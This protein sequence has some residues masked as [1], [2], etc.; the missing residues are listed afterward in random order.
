M[1]NSNLWISSCW[2]PD[3]VGRGDG[4]DDYY[5]AQ[6]AYVVTGF[7]FEILNVNIAGLHLFGQASDVLE[8]AQLFRFISIADRRNVFALCMELI[9]G[10]AAESGP[11][12]LTICPPRRNPVQC[13][14]IV[15]LL[16]DSQTGARGFLWRMQ[17]STARRREQE[18]LRQMEQMQAMSRLAH[19]VSHEFRNLLTG[20][21]IHADVVEVTQ[22]PKG[23]QESL[24]E[25]RN[26]CERAAGL[27]SQLRAFKNEVN[28]G[29]SVHNIE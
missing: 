27:L 15:N 14:A 1:P 12:D 25:I 21:R 9:E 10:N 13:C 26:S 18:S 5:L 20:I 16:R 2:K 17:D 7:K 11:V 29:G 19:T 23:R 3:G 28:F 4:Y 8:R 22:C 6:D 24:D